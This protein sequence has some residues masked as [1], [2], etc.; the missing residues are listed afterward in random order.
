MKYIKLDRGDLSVSY[1]GKDSKGN[2]IYDVDIES[3]A[4]VENHYVRRCLETPSAYL[5]LYE[6]P[7]LDKVDNDFG[8]EVYNYLSELTNINLLSTFISVTTKA[9]TYSKEYVDIIDLSVEAIDL[10]QVS[11]KV[12]FKSKESESVQTANIVI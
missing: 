7:T 11:I 6:Y 5:T 10:Y 3:G 2:S 4:I 12:S 8:N 1:K 9:L